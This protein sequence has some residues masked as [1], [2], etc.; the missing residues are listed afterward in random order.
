MF[1]T[2]LQ[3]RSLPMVIHTEVG[4]GPSQLVRSCSFIFSRTLSASNLK[5]DRINAQLPSISLLGSCQE[6]FLQKSY[7]LGFDF[8]LQ[9][10]KKSNPRTCSAHL[11]FF[12]PPF[13][14]F[15]LPFFSYLFLKFF[16]SYHTLNNFDF[17]QNL[18]P[19]PY[20]TPHINR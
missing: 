8:V 20:G 3:D 2:R 11:L 18:A 7:N 10:I 17:Y 15:F 16:L 1:S 13:F 5:N 12:S 9:H 4:Q 19:Y 6:N 14:L